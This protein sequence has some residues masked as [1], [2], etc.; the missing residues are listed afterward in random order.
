MRIPPCQVSPFQKAIMLSED[1]RKESKMGNLL[2]LSFLL[3]KGITALPV[4]L[5]RIG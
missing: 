3:Y 2:C 5:V 4:L 1:S